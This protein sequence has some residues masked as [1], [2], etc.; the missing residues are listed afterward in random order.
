MRSRSSIISAAALALVVVLAPETLAKDRDVVSPINSYIAEA[1]AR[2]NTQSVSPGS[3]YSTMGLLGDA[4]RDLQA[5]Q[6]DDIVTI[7]VADRASAVSRGVTNTGR[8]SGASAS[9]SSLFGTMP[10]AGSLANLAELGGDQKLQGQGETSRETVLT[11]TISARVTNVLPNGYLVIEGN[12]DIL[13]NS[14]RQQISVRGVVR[15]SDI[16]AAN[17]VN[18]D[19]LAELEI[20]VNGKGVVGDAIR[21]PNIVYRILM[22]ILPF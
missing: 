7:V 13:I 9:V 16:G 8:K 2:A 17:Q 10:A 18:S 21:R 15:W 1:T 5:R 19:R 20:R 12:K 14:E 4:S 22:G 6:L 3:L 11:T